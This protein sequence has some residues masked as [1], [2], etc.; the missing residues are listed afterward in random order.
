MY[1][2]FLQLFKVSSSQISVF[3][4]VFRLVLGSQVPRR[5]AWQRPRQQRQRRR[6]WSNCGGTKLRPPPSQRGA[7]CRSLRRRNPRGTVFLGMDWSLM[8]DMI[9]VLDIKCLMFLWCFVVLPSFRS[10]M[11]QHVHAIYGN[12]FM[13]FAS[14]RYMPRLCNVFQNLDTSTIVCWF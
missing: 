13:L 10:W 12:F 1:S 9:G 5:L 3:S 8:M 14:F 2:E 7:Y 11:S 4:D 6:P